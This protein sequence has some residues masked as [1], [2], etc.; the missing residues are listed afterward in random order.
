MKMKNS[1]IMDKICMAN[2]CRWGLGAT[3]L[4]LLLVLAPL[5]ALAT[6]YEISE[7]GDELCLEVQ[8]SGRITTLE[9][10]ANG[11]GI[12]FCPG[13]DGGFYIREFTLDSAT[14]LPKNVDNLIP[15]EASRF[16]PGTV[17][18]SSPYWSIFKYGAGSLVLEKQLSSPVP[19]D[20]VKIQVDE[21][22][23]PSASPPDR[24]YGWYAGIYHNVDLRPYD[25]EPDTHDLYCLVF[26]VKT[27]CGWRALGD[28]DGFGSNGLASF[29]RHRVSGWV[30][31][32]ASDP[33]PPPADEAGRFPASNCYYW[34]RFDAYETTEKMD[35]NG[36]TRFCGR[37]YRPRAA[38]W[39]RIVL[40]ADGFMPLDGREGSA[41][42]EVY[43]D[44]VTFFKAPPTCQVVRKLGF[45]L[46][47]PLF[48]GNDVELVEDGNPTHEFG[49]K[50]NVTMTPHEHHLSVEGK[51]INM[52]GQPARA[53]DLG[54]ALPIFQD[55]GSQDLKWSYDIRNSILLAD[56]QTLDATRP[57]TFPGPVD[58]RPAC[59]SRRV[60]PTTKF[61]H[62][63]NMHVSAYP[64]SSLDIDKPGLPLYGLAYGDV[65]KE[66]SGDPPLTPGI[67]HFGYRVVQ[68]ED[69]GAGN[70]FIGQYIVE[71]H[72]GLLEGAGKSTDFSFII[73]RS[74]NEDFAAASSF[75]EGLEK[76]QRDIY[77]N[78][79]HRPT[80]TIEEDW[81]LGG[82]FY[83]AD[84]ADTGPRHGFDAAP[85]DYGFRYTQ[86]QGNFQELLEFCYIKNLGLQIYDRPWAGVFT[87]D[88]STPTEEYHNTYTGLEAEQDNYKDELSGALREIYV[89]KLLKVFKVP[90]DDQ[91]LFSKAPY[92][93]PVALADS[94]EEIS[95]GALVN[96]II[97]YIDQL[98]D[99]YDNDPYTIPAR[100][101]FSGVELDNTFNEIGNSNHLDLGGNS[102]EAFALEDG[103]LTY[104]FNQFEPAIPQLCT[105]VWYLPHLRT[106]LADIDRNHLY[107]G[108]N[109]ASGNVE[110]EIISINANEANFG[111]SKYGIISADVIGFESSLGNLWNNGDHA[112]NFRRSMARDK[113]VARLFR[114]PKC[115]PDA[116]AVIFDE[117]GDG[118]QPLWV[119]SYDLFTQIVDEASWIAM[120]WGFHP[121]ISAIFSEVYLESED[122]KFD[123]M[124]EDH[125]HALFVPGPLPG[126]AGITEVF[127]QLHLAGWQ[128]ITNAVNSAQVSGGA[129]GDPSKLFIERF[130]P[131]EVPEFIRP[132][133]VTVLNNKELT[134]TLTDVVCDDL[135]DVPSISDMESDL[136][137]D[138]SGI[139]L[140]EYADP[141]EYTQTK[142]DHIITQAND[143]LTNFW[144]DIHN[145]A[146]LGLG[147][148]N[149]MGMQLIE[150]ESNPDAVNSPEIH[151]DSFTKYGYFYSVKRLPGL[152]PI[153]RIGGPS[154]SSFQPYGVIPDKGLMVFKIWVDNKV[155]NAG[156]GGAGRGTEGNPYYQRYGNWSTVSNETARQGTV[157]VVQ[158]TELNASALF[159]ID[160][161][162]R[163]RY[164]VRI[165]Y[166]ETDNGTSA[167]RYD[168]YF[169]ERTWD[170]TGETE[171]VGSEP[172]LTTIVDQSD[173]HTEAM[174]EEGFISIGEVDVSLG[175]EVDEVTVVVRVSS[176]GAEYHQ[177]E[178]TLLLADTIKLEALDQ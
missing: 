50:I 170:E 166:P 25:P 7:P 74:D 20:V 109:S 153:V 35:A 48:S 59:T 97:G 69:I 65:L 113:S 176:G 5:P 46:P 148:F 171:S 17:T 79:F 131:R 54:F 105:N 11:D 40:I 136:E 22:P 155:D 162:R 169:I 53:I 118:T 8:D 92:G 29:G 142:K 164:D 78:N 49:L 72:I 34:D 163:G 121:S 168:V 124:V 83:D 26:E 128:P 36:L 30:E 127:R 94:W 106:V 129:Q 14:R 161:R 23:N 58:L 4:F 120:A 133:Y 32:F 84:P 134:L 51:L 43:F 96:K 95:R 144:I 62:H 10:G 9:M 66:E 125:L 91:V 71:F 130:G 115:L 149:L 101:C 99:D 165:A 119:H 6:D 139:C 93:F 31:W 147:N 158:S 68:P 41:F 44:N 141:G 173:R 87:N 27:E 90:P 156:E 89:E 123:R 47:P 116:M 39:A 150:H 135:E 175:G 55:P 107:G 73:F 98:Y 88:Y 167:A 12:T 86:S 122:E 56:L 24:E 117:E 42:N 159:S 21:T 81:L 18:G 177:G 80:L 76:Y 146:A 100:R 172:V 13:L 37:T 38:K 140:D 178:A 154:N 151:S 85:N 57:I 52:S 104:S 19:N 110:Q 67:S 82:G 103:R 1:G 108:D 45:P 2:N 145:P 112:F 160:V 75:R 28:P 111:G 157:D 63:N 15:A 138:R 143:K 132:V 152:D 77:P 102:Q 16:D 126:D 61:K 114:P 64:I 3:I 60:I 137:V 70:T 174:D 33:G